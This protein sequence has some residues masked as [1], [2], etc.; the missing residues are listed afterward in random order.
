M[1]R[2]TFVK[3]SCVCGGLCLFGSLPFTNQSGNSEM[4]NFENKN[5]PQEMNQEQV[6]RIIKFIDSFRDEHVKENIFCRLG[7][8]CFY[9]RKLNEWIEQYTGNVQ[10]FLDGV[11]IEKKSKYWERLEFNEERTTLS[12]IGKKVNGCACSFADTPEPPKSLFNYC[13]KNFQ[14]ELFGKLLGQK[15]RVEITEAFLLGNECCSTLIQI[16]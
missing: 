16:V 4:M 8:E 15:V 6:K 9:S 11:N 3:S 5:I 12:L 10:V 1:D 7:Y 13:C 14:Q 2:R